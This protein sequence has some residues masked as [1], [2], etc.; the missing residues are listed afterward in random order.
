MSARLG[1]RWATASS[2]FAIALLSPIS[3]PV[4]AQENRPTVLHERVW[5]IPRDMISEPDITDRLGRFE[6]DSSG[7]YTIYGRKGERIGEAKPRPDG[8]MDL[9]DKRGRQGLEIRPE[10]PRRK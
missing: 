8:A 4:V 6:K 5:S 9:Y 10:R 7:A 3:C 2:W 1:F